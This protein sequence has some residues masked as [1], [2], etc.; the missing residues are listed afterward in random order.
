MATI[1][2]SPTGAA[3]QGGPTDATGPAAAD[4]ADRITAVPGV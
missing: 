3:S 4:Q 2:A 1:P